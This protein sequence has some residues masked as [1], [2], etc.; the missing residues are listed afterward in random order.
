MRQLQEKY[1][2]IE[3]LRLLHVFFLQ[4]ILFLLPISFKIISPLIG[5]LF[6]SGIILIVYNK[7]N[8]Q[9]SK[10]QLL[11]VGFYG[12]LILGVLWSDNTKMALFDLEV[13]MSLI[14]FPLLMSFI[15]YTEK[16]KKKGYLSFIAGVISSFVYLLVMSCVAYFETRN[17][18]TFFYANFST[19][20]HPSYLSMYVI[21]AII[22]LLYAHQIKTTFSGSL[23]LLILV[24]LSIFNLLLFSKI[25]LIAW[26]IV[27]FY[28]IFKRFKKST[29]FLLLA[30]LVLIS[31]L[32]YSNSKL[33]HDRVDELVLGL[34]TEYGGDNQGSSSVRIKIW[35]SAVELIIE[36][37]M[38]GYGTGD[39]KDNLMKKYEEHAV[40]SAFDKK[41]NAHNQ[42]L[43]MGIALGLIGMLYFIY[44][45][46]QN[47]YFN[48][49]HQNWT[50]FWFIIVLIIY[51][52]PESI[53]ENQAGS[54]FFGLFF[55]LLNQQSQIPS[56][57]S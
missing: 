14:L 16:E 36:K 23:M 9:P 41:L 13:K 45:F 34:T 28:A 54:I 4:C 42:F 6:L 33:V 17:L 10:P 25:G 15:Q 43:Q 27:I 26:L 55:A 32:V 57:N 19:I 3:W 50:A 30:L 44:I 38:F 7:L 24:T 1:A 56:A 12:L 8:F 48:F 21:L 5:L 2:N 18:D 31:S 29:S 47:I 35:E 40:K 20:I 51:A 22:L 11:L 39:V 53:L 37:P 49:H 52:I 46:S